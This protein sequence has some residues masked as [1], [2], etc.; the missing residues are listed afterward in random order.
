MRLPGR[1]DDMVSRFD[2]MPFLRRIEKPPASRKND[3][4][5]PL[6]GVCVKGEILFSCRKPRKLDIERVTTP[7]KALI[8]LPAK[9]Q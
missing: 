9:R 5:L 2:L 6:R 4:V 7:P 8:F 3:V 1:T